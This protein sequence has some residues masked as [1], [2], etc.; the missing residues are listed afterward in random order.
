MIRPSLCVLPCDGGD[1]ARQRGPQPKQRSNRPC[2]VAPGITF[3]HN[4]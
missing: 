1:E 2:D 3:T 4:V